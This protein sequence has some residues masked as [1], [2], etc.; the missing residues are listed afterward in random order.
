MFDNLIIGEDKIG[1][2]FVRRLFSVDG[3]SMKVGTPLTADQIKSWTNW[4]TMVNNGIIAVYP[5]SAPVVE[6]R[7]PGRP[8]KSH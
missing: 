3:V 5:P 2:G 1:G 7:G 6:H 4:R 8:P